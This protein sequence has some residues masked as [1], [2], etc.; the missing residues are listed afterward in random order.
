MKNTQADYQRSVDRMVYK[1][2]KV[3][4]TGIITDLVS[5]ENSTYHDELMEFALSDDYMAA[6]END[7]YGRDD[8]EL[9]EFLDHYCSG[10][11]PSNPEKRL[12]DAILSECECDD[13]LAESYVSHF[14]LY[15][16]P[17]E[18]FEYWAVSDWLAT[19]LEEKRE[20]ILSAYG[21][22]IWG[23]QTSGQS[24]SMDYVI[25]KIFDESL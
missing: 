9:I 15:P 2:V 11:P 24:I 25:C 16:E 3:C 4:L 13:D 6:L 21:L 18:I 19:K 7:I 22:N 17:R 8:E 10:E 12:C 14:M 1:E 5:C 23:R 20:A